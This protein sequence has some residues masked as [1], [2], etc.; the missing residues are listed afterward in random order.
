MMVEVKSEILMEITAFQSQRAGKLPTCLAQI[1]QSITISLLAVGS[2][3]NPFLKVQSR[4][5]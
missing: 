2:A 1:R 3:E 5:I 4:A